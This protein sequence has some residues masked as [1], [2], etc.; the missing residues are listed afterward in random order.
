VIKIGNVWFGFWER[1]IFYPY[2]PRIALCF[3]STDSIFEPHSFIE[4]SVFLR[5]WADGD[6]R[7]IWLSTSGSIYGE[8]ISY[9]RKMSDFPATEE[10]GNLLTTSTRLFISKNDL[11]PILTAV[12]WHGF[13]SKQAFAATQ[14]YPYLP[15]QLEGLECFD[16]GNHLTSHSRDLVTEQLLHEFEAKNLWPLLLGQNDQ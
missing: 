8:G 11:R 6:V 3:D 9:G 1:E 2:L 15:V 13:D 16:E 14:G 7:L 10:G 5:N 4:G 12:P